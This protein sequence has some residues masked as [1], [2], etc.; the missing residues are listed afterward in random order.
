M[1]DRWIGLPMLGGEGLSEMSR[2]LGDLERL[3]FI[4]VMGFIE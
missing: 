3:T 2:C 4:Y 1:G